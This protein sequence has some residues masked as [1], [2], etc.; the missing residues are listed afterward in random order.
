VS[1]QAHDEGD[2]TD[3][4]ES[5]SRAVVDSLEEDGDKL[6]T[7]TRSPQSQWKSIRTSNAMYPSGGSHLF[8]LRR[9]V[10]LRS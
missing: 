10:L 3:A 1:R 5:L 6:F 4:R 7:F 2:S 8:N 9:S